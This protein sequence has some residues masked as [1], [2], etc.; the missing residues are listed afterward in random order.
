MNKGVRVTIAVAFIGALG[1]IFSAYISS[2]NGSNKPSVYSFSGI[3]RD[4]HGT[5]ITDAVV[6][7]AQDQEVP[8]T[9]T[10]DSNGLFTVLLK[11]STQTLHLNVRAHG[12][13]SR[14]IEAQPHRTGPEIVT[15]QP[16]L[17]IFPVEPTP[18]APF[19]KGKSR[20]SES[21][22]TPH[23]PMAKG[24][25]PSQSS[26]PQETPSIQISTGPQSPNINGVSGGVNTTYKNSPPQ[27][28]PK[29]GDT[30]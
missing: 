6:T 23:A 29:N 17:Q 20:S 8:E 9:R 25:K 28:S 21:Q 11:I 16:D 5:P 3:V 27:P 14:E 26:P 18:Q 24:S 22:T 15:L 10:T 12:Y 1:S 2:C 13:I 30:P 7:S 4:D 19:Q